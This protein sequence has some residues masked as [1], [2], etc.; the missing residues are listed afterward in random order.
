[1]RDACASPGLAEL[2]TLAG[3]RARLADPA[4]AADAAARIAL[5]PVAARAAHLG[6]PLRRAHTVDAATRRAWRARFGGLDPACLDPD[7]APFA[8]TLAAAVRDDAALAALASPLRAALAAL[9]SGTEP[10]PA[11]ARTAAA[12]AGTDAHAALDD[13]PDA[14]RAVF[15]E[16][17]G[18][19]VGPALPDELYAL[20]P[21]RS[22]AWRLAIPPDRVAAVAAAWI[23][24]LNHAT[25]P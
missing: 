17:I 2:P 20:A 19:L 8:R 6:L 16:L 21:H 24:D 11:F 18:R 5:A 13:L 14:P 1:M 7:A 10:D 23:A 12:L 9:A 25:A 22:P 15:V 3:A 4:R